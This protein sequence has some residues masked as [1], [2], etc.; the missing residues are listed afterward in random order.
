MKKVGNL[1]NLEV[2]K[3]RKHQSYP[4]NQTEYQFDAVQSSELHSERRTEE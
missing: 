1:K 4:H 2:L 3:L